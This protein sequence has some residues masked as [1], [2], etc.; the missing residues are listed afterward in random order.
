MIV[1]SRS[2]TR[3]D[4]VKKSNLRHLSLY[5]AS[6]PESQQYATR[7]REY[8]AKA[9]SVVGRENVEIEIKYEKKGERLFSGKSAPLSLQSMPKGM[10]SFLVA[11]DSIDLDLKAA[12]PSV[13]LGLCQK[14]NVRVPILTEYVEKM[15]QWT[16]M[17]PDKKIRNILLFGSGEGVTED[18]LPRWAVDWK[19]E[20]KTMV[21]ALRPYYGDIWGVVSARDEE[22][23]QERRK[24]KQK[25]DKSCNL[26]GKFL[27]R[28][29][30]RY[31]TLILQE[32][33][34][35]GRSKGWWGNRVSFMF[36]GIVV[37]KP[38]NLDIAELQNHV[39]SKVG[40]AIK[41]RTKPWGPGM[42][43]DLNQ[44]PP[45]LAVT[46]HHM[47][48]A[49]L[50]LLEVGDILVRSGDNG[51]TTYMKSQGVWID[52]KETVHQQLT[53]MIQQRDIRM[54]KENDSTGECVY[55]PFSCIYSQAKAIKDTMIPM[56][57]I[58]N[59][60]SKRLVLGTFRKL[61]YLDGFWEFLDAPV[62][63]TG[64]YGRFVQGGKFDT[65]VMIR[66]PFP[67]RVQ[68]DI[69]FVMEKILNPLFRA[70]MDQLP[71][72]LLSV[73]RAM[74]GHTDKITN[75]LEGGRDS[76]KSVSMQLVRAAFSVYC[77]SF[78]SEDLSSSFGGD[79]YR[80]N[81]W[82]IEM[83]H[84]R[85]A[86]MSEVKPLVPGK[87]VVL[88]GDQLKKI[89]SCKEGIPSRKLYQRPRDYV[90]LCALYMLLNDIP[91]FSPVDALQMCHFYHFGTTFVTPEVKAK[92]PFRSDFM[93][94]NDDIEVWVRDPKYKAAMTWIVI[95]SYR[96]ERVVPLESMLETNIAAMDEEGEAMYE[97][98]F[99]ITLDKKDRI[100]TTAMLEIVRKCNQSINHQRIKRELQAIVD[101]ACMEQ[102]VAKFD[103]KVKSG[104][105][106]YYCGIRLRANGDTWDEEEE[107]GSS[108]GNTMVI[109]VPS[110]I[111]RSG[112]IP[113]Q[114]A[115][116][117]IAYSTARP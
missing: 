18:R 95:E 63:D 30:Y 102:N 45:L 51:N 41:L 73:A 113:F 79:S 31:E 94:K 109:G 72:F 64:V 3:Y 61:A 4:V 9:G 76:G 105:N 21:D 71:L 86:V 81:Q 42:V 22:D 14:F 65:G 33:D 108:S 53:L 66:E 117:E 19:K 5:G 59:E 77:A 100:K 115:N 114:M 97:R 92:N 85:I 15:D 82:I 29:Y 34:A 103:V 47:E 39:L 91:Q 67:I 13:L 57:R 101:T 2:I 12:A 46:N 54:L 52:D 16:A 50:F 1:P 32:V 20:I 78:N 40:I 87:P 17:L 69:D 7:L 70:N 75:G 27:S 58:E 111:D 98:L 11:D 25:I 44:P 28:L 26:D 10:R 36:D 24:K 35:Y 93:L 8:M 104:N 88:S 37:Y 49:E 84:A 96:P 62:E 43:V 23:K 112:P 107:T 60:F 80:Q 83:E 90:S 110:T 68:Q 106:R 55:A 89:Q 48:A 74:A 38:S 6:Y 116:G 56:I 99:E